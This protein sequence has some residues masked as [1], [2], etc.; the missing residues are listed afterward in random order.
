MDFNCFVQSLLLCVLSSTR[1]CANDLPHGLF[2]RASA[3]WRCC[4]TSLDDTTLAKVPS[5]QVGASVPRAA[6]WHPAGSAPSMSSAINSFT[7]ILWPQVPDRPSGTS[8]APDGLWRSFATAAQT[9]EAHQTGQADANAQ[10]ARVGRTWD[11]SGEQGASTAFRII[12][13]PADGNCLFHSLARGIRDGKTTA[14]SLRSDI[15][16]FI[17]ENPTWQVSDTYLR[18]WIKW[19]S[20]MDVNTYARRMEAG[21]WGGGIEMA[22]FSHLKQV[23]VIVYQRV[24][25]QGMDGL[26]FKRISSFDSPNA[27][28]TVNVL[29][30]GGKHYDALEPVSSQPPVTMTNLLSLRHRA[31]DSMWKDYPR[32]VAAR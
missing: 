25:K 5:R 28:K 26:V 22:V 12:G 14:S 2:D 27:R 19:D 16:N 10:V 23:N 30:R 29:Y 21:A 20:D 8:A 4:H 17:R 1:V 7:A 18:R 13:Q 9:L 15:A 3:A 31:D 6:H 24:Q 11:K 32:A